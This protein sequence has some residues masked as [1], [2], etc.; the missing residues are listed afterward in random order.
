MVAKIVYDRI[1]FYPGDQIFAEGDEGNWA[2]LIQSGQIE[3]V[4]QTPDGSAMRVALLKA[5]QMFGEMALLEELPR[6]AS[7]RAISESVVVLISAETMLDRI[8]KS[9][10]L[11]R[12]MLNNMSKN[13]RSTVNRKVAAKPAG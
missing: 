7:A 4:K 5:G 12:A 10:P 13:L 6:M 2:Y 1:V 11:I 9:D 3:I 8:G